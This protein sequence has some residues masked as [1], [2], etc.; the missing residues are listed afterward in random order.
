MEQEIERRAK[1]IAQQMKAL[2]RKIEAGDE[3][4]LLIWILPGVLA[5]SHRPLRHHP[6]YGGSG[7]NLA[8]DATPLL[9]EWVR[10][11]H[12][13]GIRS[14]LC[15]MHDKELSYYSALELGARDLLHFYQNHGFETRR[16]PWEDPAHSKTG[17]ASIRKTM[18]IV[19]LQ[20]LREFRSMKKPVVLH[21]SAGRDRSAP[22]AAYIQMR[23]MS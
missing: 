20:C 11:M 10:R 14:I 2:G 15:L 12:Q 7:R 3:S 23:S 17:L 9:H 6:L 4:D 21:C 13:F 5:C 8:K 1:E 19:Q 16:I 18:H 22:V